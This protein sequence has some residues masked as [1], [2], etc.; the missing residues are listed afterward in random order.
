MGQIGD[1]C[2][3]GGAMD[4]G[5]KSVLVLLCFEFLACFS[6][7]SSRFKC[8][9]GGNNG[10]TMDSSGEISPLQMS[11]PLSLEKRIKK[12]FKIWS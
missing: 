3:T 6:E 10:L 9:E 4:Q 11:S 8:W 7:M 2:K 12:E 5:W 1:A